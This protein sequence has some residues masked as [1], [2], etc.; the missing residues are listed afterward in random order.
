V[1]WIRDTG[2]G[3]LHILRKADLSSAGGPVKI[4]SMISQS[5][6]D[7][8]LIYLLLLALISINLALFNLIPVPILDGGQLLLATIESLIGRPLPIKVREYIFIG[9]WLLF[10]GLILVLSFQDL[11]VILKPYLQTIKQC[12]PLSL[13]GD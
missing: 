4:I 10:I 9:T 1:R 7:G 3:L 13:V 11:A 8:I 5:A 12:I 6:Q 2:Y